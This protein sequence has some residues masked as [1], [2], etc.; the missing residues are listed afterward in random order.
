MSL[1]IEA[2]MRLTDRAAIEQQLEQLGA[3]R[4]PTILEQN[5][6]F[7]TDRHELKSTDQGLRIRV[8]QHD[9]KPFRATMTHKGPRAHGQ[10]KSRTET[11][12]G[13]DNARAAAE[14]L[15]ALGF[16]PLLSFEKRRQRW[17]LDGCNVE[18]DTLPYL[19]EFIE[20]EG[21][22]DDAVLSVRERLGMS[23][24]PLIRASYVAMLV[25]YLREN[26]L[27]TNAVRLEDDAAHSK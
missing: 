14:M 27:H 5:T 2:K 24:T 23:E 22:S 9:G 13:V 18:M 12:V 11:E 20:I 3:E 17:K 1:E 7:D 25:S 21:P 19:G 8:E 15:A 6:Y 10:L 16:F 26:H 4:G